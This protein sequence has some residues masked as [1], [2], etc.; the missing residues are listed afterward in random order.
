MK[1][2]KLWL[3]SIIAFVGGFISK[4]FDLPLPEGY[5]DLTA[6]T[7]MVIAGLIAAWRTKLKPNKS[8]KADLNFTADPNALPFDAS[9]SS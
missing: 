9:K 3:V 1:L 7:I 2:D 8:P 4:Q 5:E 6:E